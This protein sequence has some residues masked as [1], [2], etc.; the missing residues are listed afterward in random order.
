MGRR[1]RRCGPPDAPRGPGYGPWLDH[2]AARMPG[3]IAPRTRG[4]V[5]ENAQTL[6]RSAASISKRASGSSSCSASVNYSAERA[7][8]RV[9]A[10]YGRVS[11]FTQTR[12]V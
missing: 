2:V 6:D 10:A 9:T 4:D 12:L 8:D 3:R 1:E 7:L 11:S 5:R